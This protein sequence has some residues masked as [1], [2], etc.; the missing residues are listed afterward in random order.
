MG[1][2]ASVS[3]LDALLPGGPERSQ[4]FFWYFF[5][6]LLNI[7]I[8]GDESLHLLN[9]DHNALLLRDTFSQLLKTGQA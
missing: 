2:R 1:S 9:R 6:F 5:C 8:H 3:F 4:T 7:F